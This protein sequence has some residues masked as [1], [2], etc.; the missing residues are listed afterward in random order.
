MRASRLHHVAC[1]PAVPAPEPLTL[2][3]ARA[4]SETARHAYG[5]EVRRWLNG[6]YFDSERD[7]AVRTRI[8]QLMADNTEALVGTRD[9]ALI[10]G[11]NVV[12]KSTFLLQ[13]ARGVHRENVDSH[14]PHKQPYR[15]VTTLIRGKP[16]EISTPHVP[17]VVVSLEAATTVAKFDE[18]LVES[19]EYDKGASKRARYLDLLMRHGTRL[20]I[21]DDLHLLTVTESRGRQALD[22]L[23][24][25]MTAA[26]EYGITMVLAGAD[27][28]AHPVTDDPQV[29]GRAHELFIGPYR[30]DTDA[31][32]HAWQTFLK[33]VTTV[34]APHLPGMEPG[35]L[36]ERLPGLILP[37]TQGRTGAVANLI[38]H[39]T[40]HAINDGT[41]TVAE[42]HLQVAPRA[43]LLTDATQAAS[44]RTSPATKRV[45]AT[46]ARE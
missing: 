39:V 21:V 45:T 5:R 31:H 35:A 28:H 13:L 33:E 34:I 9:I 16:E 41:W 38:R 8:R 46:A 36:H 4:L 24:A 20:L 26:G 17:V 42:Q 7:R 14:D 1:T 18:L 10:T 27:L 22:H 2:G 37:L 25:I 6:H 30:S 19:F 23:K 44:P 40:V 43:K 29:T 12:G 32:R 3:Q 15:T 11:P